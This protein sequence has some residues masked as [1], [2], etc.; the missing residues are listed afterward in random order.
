MG[1]LTVSIKIKQITQKPKYLRQQYQKA[2]WKPET[3]N[4]KL[5][6]IPTRPRLF[7]LDWSLPIQTSYHVRQE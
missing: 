4:N 6:T 5:I 3:I 1:K 2:G 7:G